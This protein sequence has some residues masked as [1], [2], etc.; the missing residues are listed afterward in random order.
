MF[1]FT[2]H[3]LDNG[4]TPVRLSKDPK[5]Y[6]SLVLSHARSPHWH[7][8]HYDFSNE[9]GF[10][11][12]GAGKEL[13]DAA[14]QL[15]GQEARVKIKLEVKCNGTWTVIL[16][17]KLNFS[18]YRQEYKSNVLYTFLNAENEDITQ[19]LRN[20]EDLEVDLL[21]TTSLNGTALNLYPY[22]GYDVNMHSKTVRLLSLWESLFHG[23]C[24]HFIS[25]GL[26]LLYIIPT[27]NILK[28]D[29]EKT[30]A[31]ESRC[32]NPVVFDGFLDDA[33]FI[34]NTTN[35][36]VFV[37]PNVVRVTWRIYGEIAITTYNVT[38]IPTACDDST[39]GTG[40]IDAKLYDSVDMT[41]RLFFGNPDGG[42]P[43]EAYDCGSTPVSQEGVK[44]IDLVTVPTFA[45][46]GNPMVKFF[47]SGIEQTRDIILN[48]GDRV[49]YYWLVDM[50][51]IESMDMKIEFDYTESKLELL[52]DTIYS[53]T[54]CKAIAVHEAWS[55]LSEV[56]TDQPTA[57]RSEF[58]GRTNSN[59]VYPANGCGGLVALTSGK[60]I[61]QLEGSPPILMSLKKMYESLD[62]IYGIGLGIER[63]GGFDVVRVEE[64]S[65]FYSNTEILKLDF[66]PN[67]QM[68]HLEDKVYNE[69][70]IGFKRWE[71][72]TSNGLDEPLTKIEY[73][74][75]PIKNNKQ[76]FEKLSD[77][78]AGMYAIELT[79]RSNK[80]QTKDTPYDEEAFILALKSDLVNCEKD[81]IMSSIT[82]LISPETAYNLRFLLSSTFDRLKNQFTSGLTKLG[83]TTMPAEGE[84][85]Q[86]V[87]YAYIPTGCAGDHQGATRTNGADG[88]YPDATARRNEPLFLP[89]QYVF[90]WPLSFS[91]Y[92]NLVN[93]PY[94][95][96]KFSSTNKNY[97]SGWVTNLDYNVR[98]KSGEFT[99]IRKYA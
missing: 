71:T 62:A 75:P 18:T 32:V 34:V 93:N 35:S 6:E 9:F 45:V 30:T 33:Q 39:C 98:N 31:T 26:R 89:E 77:F 79:R 5:G 24:F 42:N 69:I 1:R 60:N 55:R 53:E 50:N 11:C 94:G 58:F 19:I 13:V 88:K 86:N 37:E 91:D 73:V 16:K 76:K 84:G 65:Y 21:R 56:I 17:G 3:N 25:T 87:T 97:I 57:F 15:K 61:R 99:I 64:L 54:T 82:G 81:E 48:P 83:I 2:L 28:G 7:G 51:V 10:F 40:G 41:L 23:C 96:I 92:L 67:I 70:S 68:K 72:L 43:T 66:V 4:S 85:N 63:V 80:E 49:W 12:K 20:R 90:S 78:V 27:T 46:A 52:S 29:F 22:A 74:V 36:K 44:Y 95:L 59:V 8:V 47:S 14:Y 38:P